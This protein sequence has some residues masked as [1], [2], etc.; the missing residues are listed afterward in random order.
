MTK[1]NINP[2]HYKSMG[3]EC[4]DCI[5]GAVMDLPGMQGYLTGNVMKYIWRFQRKN[6][7]EDLNKAKWYLER[8]IKTVEE[9]Q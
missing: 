4:I 6:G 3:L 1:D 2:E 8:L 5:Q 9:A 7:V